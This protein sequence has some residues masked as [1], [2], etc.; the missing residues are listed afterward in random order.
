MRDIYVTLHFC[1][2]KDMTRHNL[3]SDKIIKVSQL[4]TGAILSQK[5]VFAKFVHLH[6]K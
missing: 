3:S 6:C 5:T 2:K 1:E 4:L